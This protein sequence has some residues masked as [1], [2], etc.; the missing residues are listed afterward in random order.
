[1]TQISRLL[2]M[3]ITTNNV[4]F[5]AGLHGGEVQKYSRLNYTLCFGN[6]IVDVHNHHLPEKFWS[7]ISDSDL[8]TLFH[9]LHN[10]VWQ[11]RTLRE[12]NLR[13]CFEM[14]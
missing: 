10:P 6:D 5:R 1:M 14:M 13:K 7:G 9:L 2:R 11:V 8:D 3:F 12:M 4:Y